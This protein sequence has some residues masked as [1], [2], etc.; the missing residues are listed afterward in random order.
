MF[1]DIF[2]RKKILPE[3]L[4]AYGFEKGCGSYKYSAEILSGA[5][6]LEIS[7][8]TNDF[9]SGAKPFVPHIKLTEIATDEEY[10]LYKTDAAGS[11]VGEIRAAIGDVLRDIAERCFEIAIFKAKQSVMLIDYIRRKYGDELEYLWDKFPDNAVWRRK[12]NRKW[13]GILLTVSR[14]K[15][16]IESDETAEI[17]DLRS[18]PESLECL[19]DNK[20][21][22]PG[23]HMNKK[24]WYTIIMDDSV[25]FD[26]ICRRI[27]ESYL[28][29]K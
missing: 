6:R 17:I 7:I 24:H 8:N 14:R 19:V 16:G 29:A 3:K 18:T 22:Y 26:E 15:L 5:F 11:F 4:E 1:E 25:P 27:D 12:D 21:Y 9:V 13:Y 20:L 2:L 23:W 10:I 28:L